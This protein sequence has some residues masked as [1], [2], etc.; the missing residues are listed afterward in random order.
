MRRFGCDATYTP[1]G[2]GPV[3][4]PVIIDRDVEPT[5]PSQQSTTVERRTELT[6]YH[7]DLGAARRSELVEADGETWRLDRLDRDDGHLCTWWVV[8][9]TT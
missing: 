3:T 5:Q 6:A 4:I 2:G 1:S 7:S 8:R 9:V